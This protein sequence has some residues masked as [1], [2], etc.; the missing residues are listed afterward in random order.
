MITKGEF[1]KKYHISEAE[2]REAEIS[3]DDLCEIYDDY[4]EHKQSKY[5]AIRDDFF[6]TYLKDMNEGKSE[7]ERIKVHTI[8][9]RIKDPEHLLAKIVI[10]KRKNDK[11]YYKLDK[12]NYE[13]FV[14]DLLGIRCLVTFKADW[15][16]FHEYIM[17]KFEN[18]VKYYVKDSIADF[19]PDESHWYFAEEPKVHIRNGDFREIYKGVLSP[20]CIIDGKIY[21]AVHYIIKYKGIYLEIQLRTLFEES[22][23][24]IDHAI[25]YPYYKDDPILKEYTELLN[26]LAGLADEMGGFFRKLKEL[27]VEHLEHLPESLKQ[28]VPADEDAD[29]NTV[30]EVKVEDVGTLNTCGDCLESVLNE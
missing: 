29:K 14:T 6:D 25:A 15:I 10:R 26:R 12:T 4:V 27:E 11:K 18:D 5:K 1:L 28:D 20:D 17:S 16:S 22:W 8:S 24:E 23:S 3:W 9:T 30:M 13:K 19:D 21:R 2:F 7:A